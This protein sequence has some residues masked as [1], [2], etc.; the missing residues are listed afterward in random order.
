MWEHLGYCVDLRGVYARRAGCAW[1]RAICGGLAG[2][3]AVHEEGDDREDDDLRY[4]DAL[5]GHVCG[6]YRM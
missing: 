2:I 6:V 5:F 1:S 4:V 3:P